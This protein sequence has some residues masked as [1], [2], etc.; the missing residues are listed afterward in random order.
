MPYQ[1]M[2][3]RT[4]SRANAVPAISAAAQYNLGKVLFHRHQTQPGGGVNV[5]GDTGQ[6]GQDL[7]EAKGLL[8]QVLRH[9]GEHSGANLCL[10]RILA[11]EEGIVFIRRLDL[12]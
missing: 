2:Y 5:K 3:D 8:R 11:E 4:N 6:G 9:N 1:T 10:A 12:R 7:R